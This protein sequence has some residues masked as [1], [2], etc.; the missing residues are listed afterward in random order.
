MELKTLK[1]LI[2]SN[3][4]CEDPEDPK[5]PDQLYEDEVVEIKELKAEAVK[6][7]KEL[8]DGYENLK[9]ENKGKFIDKNS[10]EGRIFLITKWIKHFFNLKE[11]DLK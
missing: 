4:W 2:I 8:Q 5:A 3:C 6:W 10:D 11:E 1:D 7:V 9:P